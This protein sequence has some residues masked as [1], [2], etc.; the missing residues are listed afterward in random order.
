MYVRGIRLA[1]GVAEVNVGDD[2]QWRAR[3]GTKVGKYRL[4]ALIGVGGMA[5]VFAA[6]HENRS[7]VALKFLDPY[8]VA[9]DAEFLARF[10][11]EGLVAN[12]V[13]HE[14][15]VAVIGDGVADDGSPYLVMELLD[16]ES[17]D[18]VQHRL[19]VLPVPEAVEVLRRLL[20]VLGA[21]NAK[22]IVHRDLKPGNLFLTRSGALKVLDFG[23]ARLRDGTE[24]QATKTGAGFGTPAFMPPEQTRGR[25]KEID[26][27]TDLWAAA[28]TFFHLVS[29]QYTHVG[30]TGGMLMA[31]ISSK[32]AR[33]LA[34]V[35]PT[36]PA[37]LVAVIDRALSMDRADRFADATE[38]NAALE[39]IAKVVGPRGDEDL[40]KLVALGAISASATAQSA[41]TV[42]GTA[43]P[44]V[45]AAAAPRELGRCASC[46]AA[47]DASEL[48]HSPMFGG[49]V[50]STCIVAPNL[51]TCRACGVRMTPQRSAYAPDGSVVCLGCATRTALKPSTPF[52][53]WLVGAIGIAVFL[54]FG[55]LVFV[56]LT[57]SR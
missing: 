32:P 39:P 10:R 24:G 9:K 38:M 34:Q 36:A 7:R 12:T 4:D 41:P 55:L 16:G 40:A 49:H 35:L 22:G 19:R 13:E 3:V 48:R 31:E 51:L 20:D 29:G 15:T 54:F 28:A 50:C 45:T 11:R 6:T 2:W 53:V 5:A 43:T 37:A 14:G 47:V 42:H 52:V 56:A 27:R 26:G 18:N 30:D 44:G 17:L 46:G 25:T 33:S 8:I 23:I 21:A 1:C 57:G